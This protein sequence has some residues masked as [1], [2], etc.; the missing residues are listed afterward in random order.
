MKLPITDKSAGATRSQ[1]E[2]VACVKA[3]IGFS[4]HRQTIGAWWHYR[5]DG[6]CISVYIN[7]IGDSVHVVYHPKGDEF[8]SMN[9][10]A[11]CRAAVEGRE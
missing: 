4:S 3:G 7:G 10:I 6:R 11:A 1:Q 9:W 2:Y 8:N 5:I